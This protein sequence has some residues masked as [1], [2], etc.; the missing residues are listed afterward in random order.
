MGVDGDGCK[1]LLQGIDVILVAPVG[2]QSQDIFDFE[3]VE[4]LDS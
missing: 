1:E 3:V 2:R 4:S